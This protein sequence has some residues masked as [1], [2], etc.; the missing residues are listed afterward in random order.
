M[1]R[2]EG[3]F[4]LTSVCLLTWS[5]RREGQSGAAVQPA[6]TISILSARLDVPSMPRRRGC[7]GLAGIRA[8]C[9]RLVLLFAF[10][11]LPSFCHATDIYFA[12]SAAGG[13]N[14]ADC[15]DAY[16]YT[17]GTH[18]INISGNWVAGNTL[19]ICGTITGGNGA[20][21]V[22]WVEAAPREILSR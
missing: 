3:S 4:S 7:A 5:K 21:I 20:N 15:A 16:A 10:L 12:Q 8:L 18:G 2:R 22:T 14:G 9:S 6:G 11:L 13:N 19:H 1:S 17:D